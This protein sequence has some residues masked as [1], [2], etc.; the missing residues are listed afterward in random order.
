MIAR[1]SPTNSGGAT[2]GSVSTP[3]SILDYA[4]QTG[5]TYHDGQS[6]T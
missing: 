2:P 3:H 4:R 1:E 6:Q 5:V